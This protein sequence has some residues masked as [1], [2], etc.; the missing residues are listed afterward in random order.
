MIVRLN[1]RALFTLRAARGASIRVTSGRVWIT[2][3]G[4]AA[5]HFIAAGGDYR[6]RGDGLV[7]VENSGDAAQAGIAVPEKLIAKMRGIA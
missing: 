4:S 6:V 3:D 1:P 7:V 5:D 2:E